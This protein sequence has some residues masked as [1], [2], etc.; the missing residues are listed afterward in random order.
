MVGNKKQMEFVSDSIKNVLAIN[1][2]NEIIISILHLIVAYLIKRKIRK[3]Q[4]DFRIG[5]FKYFAGKKCLSLNCYATY[6][7]GS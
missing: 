2:S 5:A 7:V 3:K 6:H 4:F 1:F